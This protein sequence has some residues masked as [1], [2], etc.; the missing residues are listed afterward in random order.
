[1]QGQANHFLRFAK[2]KIPYG[3]QRYVGESERLYGVLNARLEGRDYIVGDKFSI[4]DIN[5]LGW[6]DASNFAALRARPAVKK[7][8]AV[9]SEAFFGNAALKKAIAADPE[10][11]KAAEEAAAL[12]KD[13][14]E[15][16]GY[17]YASP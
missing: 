3:I 15:K 1:M 11:K 13:A 7:G 5:L 8:F 16:Y 4:A 17:K 14:K 12:I 6:V 2:E 10:K 9:P